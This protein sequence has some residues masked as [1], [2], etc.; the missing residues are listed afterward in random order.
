MGALGHCME[1]TPSVTLEEDIHAQ[2]MVVV[3]L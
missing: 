3:G 1:D 2:P